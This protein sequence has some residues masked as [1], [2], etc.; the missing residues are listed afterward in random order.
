M[1]YPEDMERFRKLVDQA[2]NEL[3][4][5]QTMGPVAIELKNIIQRRTRLGS[6]VEQTGAQKTPLAELAS[7]TKLSR[8]RKKAAG[9][10]SDKTSPNKSNLTETGQMLNSLRGYARK[11]AKAGT[12]DVQPTG[13]RNRTLAAIHTLGG[14]K[15]P[16]RRFLD[17]A[18]QD[19]KQ[20]TV[21]LQ[22]KFSEILDRVFK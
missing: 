8:Q 10:L 1:G 19:I 6:G 3:I 4:S 16:K 14:P 12:I 2:M 20:L 17:L 9:L 21:V 13:D 5:Q 15:L 11:K 22:D 18:A 7:S